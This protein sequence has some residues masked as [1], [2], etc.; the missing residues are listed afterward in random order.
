[1]FAWGGGQMGFRFSLTNLGLFQ[2]HSINSISLKSS[3]FALYA[4]STPISLPDLAAVDLCMQLQ[5]P[6]YYGLVILEIQTS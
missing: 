4:P 2:T 6:D 5:A 1:M 3:G